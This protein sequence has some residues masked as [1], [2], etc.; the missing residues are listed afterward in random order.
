MKYSGQVAKRAL[1]GTSL[2]MLF[3]MLATSAAAQTASPEPASAAA[4]ADKAALQDIV[5][6]G[7]RIA[8]S[9]FSAPTPTTV[10]GAEAMQNQGIAN[11]ATL[12]NQVPAFRGSS[13]P[14]SGTFG[15]SSVGGNFVNLR[16][17][18]PNRTLVLVDSNRVV[19]STST[20]TFDL[21]LIP[22]NM[23]ER[24]EVVT[25]GAS[26]AYGSDAVSGVVNV[27]LKKHF[28]GIQAE[29]QAGISGQGD[30]GNQRLSLVA[31]SDFAE[32][33]GHILVGGEYENSAGIGTPTSRN[34]AARQTGVFIGAN[35]VRYIADN[36]QTSNMTYGGLI[37]S[38][39]LKGTAFASGGSTYNLVYGNQFGN[40]SST[41]MSGG[42]N[43][44][45]YNYA[46]NDLQ[47]PVQRYSTLARV[48]Y[49]FNDSISGYV[50]GNFAHSGG[51]HPS[52]TSRDTSLTIQRTN[53]YLPSSVAAA[54]D[55]NGL[56]T[57]SIG[58]INSDLGI[59]SSSGSNETW[60]VGTGLNGDL[61][62]GW[63]WDVYGGYGENRLKS[64][65]SNLRIDANF[66]KA[67]DAVTNP[68]NGQIVCR[69]TLTDPT[70]GCVP[71]NVFG[72]NANQTAAQNYINGTSWLRQLTYQED[73]AANIQGS[74]FS[75]WAGEVH[76]AGGGEYRKD[77]INA[78][79]DALSQANAFNVSNPKAIPSSAISVYEG[80]LETVIPLL[81]DK[82]FFKRVEFNGAIRRTHYSL[83]GSVTTWKLGGVWE[84][85]S[86]LRFR[87]T[88]SRDIRA[89]N[90][91]ETFQG[92]QSGSPLLTYNGV[93]RLT[94]TL[95]AGNRN[96]TPEIADTYSFGVGVSP[97]FLPGFRANIDYYNISINNAITVIPAQTLLDGCSAGVAAYCSRITFTNGV[98]TLVDY[99]SFNVAQVRTSGIDFELGYGFKLGRG[100]LDVSTLANYV[101][102]LV[103]T[104]SS[105]TRDRAGEI[106][107][108]LVLGGID[109]PHWIG[110]A[111][112][113][114]AIGNLGLNAHA[115]Y[116]GS[117]KLDNYLTPSQL[118]INYVQSRTYIN[119]G[120]EYN[121]PYGA[122]DR[123]MQI[124]GNINNAFDLDPPGNL[125]LASLINSSSASYYDTTGRAFTV[126]VRVRY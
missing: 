34:W 17:L 53:A 91:L 7:S 112:V 54:M 15:F 36:N 59:F 8:R 78:T 62:S 94:P 72:V 4:D 30:A 110:D 13:T 46:Q 123:K 55:A 44:N 40:A 82:H 68:A 22:S 117:G 41:V 111:N 114:Y 101:E 122:G 51:T 18:G 95:T 43:P 31:G 35:G 33:R 80:Y 113:H 93:S 108:G 84:V 75:T 52:V 89:P 67:I 1:A 70:N 121:I 48:D 115:H 12:L 61:G 60:R 98:P 47:V 21:N 125:P 83:A 107:G 106:G 5:V 96:L 37:V 97:S 79:S 118:N 29:A 3:A 56:S 27:I 69:S 38:G 81:A 49:K 25:G 109:G 66:A 74:P 92:Q 99:S 23:I 103:T 73:A 100:R 6:T 24:T 11:V 71:F 120:V 26:A 76:V 32:G 28:N 63:K 10:L 88:R 14:G 20:G 105:G 64:Q 57:I 116:I 42:N 2:S 19:P 104:D 87:A 102:K 124:F 126:G 39:P 86:D 16:A 50:T 65:L 9:G 77:G 119:L 90:L 45:S 58:R 85:S